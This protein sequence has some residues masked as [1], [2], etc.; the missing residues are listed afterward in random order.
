MRG[1]IATWSR[2]FNSSNLPASIFLPVSENWLAAR[3]RQEDRQEK[4]PCGISAA[5]VLPALDSGKGLFRRD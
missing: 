1:Q 2:F 5:P 4:L 3:W